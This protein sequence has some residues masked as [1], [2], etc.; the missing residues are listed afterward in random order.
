MNQDKSNQVQSHLLQ[1]SLCFILRSI[2]CLDDSKN[3]KKDLETELKYS[4][5]H[6]YSGASLL[7]KEIL[8]KEHWTLIIKPKDKISTDYKKFQSGDFNSINMEDSI[9]LLKNTLNIQISS[10]ELKKLKSLKLLRNK[11]EHF[12]FAN[13]DIKSVQSILG[14]NLVIILKMIKSYF[15][16]ENVDSSCQKQITFIKDKSLELEQ[17]EKSKIKEIKKNHKCLDK[18]LTCYHC[19]KDYLKAYPKRE[20]L[21]CLYCEEEVFAG[22]EDKIQECISYIKH[23]EEEYFILH[24]GKCE[25]REVVTYLEGRSYPVEDLGIPRYLCLSCFHENTYQFVC[26]RCSVEFTTDLEEDANSTYMFCPTC[27]DIQMS[28]P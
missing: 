22:D 17:Y 12:H 10:N 18:M 20:Y 26:R 27:S 16:N 1:N 23:F 4:L 3:D 24:C 25:A 9:K 8:R 28:K 11:L 7:I 5:L 13:L 21:A 2:E 19:F 15:P 6:L 14:S